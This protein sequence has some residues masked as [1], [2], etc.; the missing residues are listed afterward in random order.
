MKK[1]ITTCCVAAG[2]LMPL[3]VTTTVQAEPAYRHPEIHEAIR[4]LEAARVHLK[5]AKHD[6][7]GHREAALAAV[8]EAL[9]QLHLAI[10][11][12]K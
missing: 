12:D 5:E 4:A 3:T 8:D 11:F 6:F 7:G 2:L 10:D 1:L 9:K